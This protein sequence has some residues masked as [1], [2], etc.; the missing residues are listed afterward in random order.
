[1]GIDFVLDAPCPVKDE[2]STAGLVQLVKCRSRAEAIIDL[3]RRE[4]NNKPAAELFITQ[5][6]QTPDGLQE[7]QQISAEAL[8]DQA[9]PLAGLAHECEDCAGRLAREPFTCYG[10]IRYPIQRRTEE[11]LLSLLPDNLDSTAGVLLQKSVADFGYD[12]GPF[13]ALRSNPAFFESPQESQRTWR[14][15]GFLGR[16][17]TAFTLTSTQLLQM[18]FGVGELQPAHCQMLCLFLGLVPHDIASEQLQNSKTY[19][20][21][22]FAD[23]DVPNNVPD[24]DG[25]IHFCDALLR[26]VYIDLP[27]GIDY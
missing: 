12:G 11:W 18:M 25:F 21:V 6:L 3:A 9:A 24:V 4:G 19:L 5:I 15:K 22:A 23:Y 2:L 16:F 10:S 1:M 7:Q 20:R 27:V 13:V 26:A 17:T 14:G 8:L